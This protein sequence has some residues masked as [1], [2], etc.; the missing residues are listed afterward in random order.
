MNFSGQYNPH[1]FTSKDD[2]INF[3]IE[4]AFGAKMEEI[5]EQRAKM[6]EEEDSEKP[7]FLFRFYGEGIALSFTIICFGSIMAMGK[8]MFRT[9]FSMKC[10]IQIILNV[11]SFAHSASM[12]SWVMHE[13][14]RDSE[15][16]IRKIEDSMKHTL[17]AFQQCFTLI[18]LHE[19]YKML[20]ELKILM[21][22]IIKKTLLAILAAGLAYGADKALRDMCLPQYFSETSLWR[23]TLKE[24]DLFTYLLVFLNTLSILY[25][26]WKLI[27]SVRESRK[28]R[29]RISQ[30][31]G[32]SPSNHFSFLIATVT[33][34][35]LFQVLKLVSYTV[36]VYLSV[37][38]GIW[39]KRCSR[40]KSNFLGVIGCFENEVDR[41][42]NTAVFLEIYLFYVSEIPFITAMIVGKRIQE[43]LNG[44][45]QEIRET[46]ETQETD[47]HYTDSDSTIH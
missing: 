26:T 40:G 38:N 44:R 14:D 39:L 19:L 36:E 10:V 8:S 6:Q 5:N 4:T 31:N 21:T 24:L 9:V 41:D 15:L 12:Y 27:A 1:N 33:I 37:F 29:K 20:T 30:Q 34:T 25:C 11:L 43:L 17:T 23:I 47:H 28:F 16:R 35:T 32:T 42:I 7:K 2:V 22:Q 3:L 46:Q 13:A 18:L 45:S